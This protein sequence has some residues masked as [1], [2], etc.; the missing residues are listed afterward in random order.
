MGASLTEVEELRGLKNNIRR[1]VNALEICWSC[2]V[3]CEASAWKL[4]GRRQVWLCPAC[5]ER[6]KKHL[7]EAVQKTLRAGSN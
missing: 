3:V 5:Y 7:L 6:Q 2:E 1:G 4:E